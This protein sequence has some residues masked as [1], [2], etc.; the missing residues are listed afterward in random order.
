MPNSKVPQFVR[1]AVTRQNIQ[2]SRRDWIKSNPIVPALK[3][4]AILS[5][6]SGIVNPVEIFRNRL[7]QRRFPI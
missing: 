4:R 3:C 7:R 5:D 1:M 6:P 2:P